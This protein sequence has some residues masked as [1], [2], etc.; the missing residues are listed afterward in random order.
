MGAERM[1]IEQ[2]KYFVEVA[3]CGSIRKASE[4]LF[5]AQQSLSQSVKK[6]ET[7]LGVSLLERSLGGV[8][9]TREGEAVLS[10]A[11]AVLAEQDVLTGQLAAIAREKQKQNLKGKLNIY[12]FGVYNLFILPSALKTF[13][14]QYPQVKIKIFTIDFELLMQALQNQSDVSDFLGLVILPDLQPLVLKDFVGEAPVQ[15]FPLVRG[16]YLLCCSQAHPLAKKRHVS[17][18]QLSGEPIVDYTMSQFENGA[19]YKIA[20][21]YGYTLPELRMETQSANLWLDMI[22]EGQGIGFMNE[23]L[24]DGMKRADFAGIDKV[25]VVPLTEPVYGILGCI[26]GEQRG[27][28]VEKFMEFL[29]L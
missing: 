10:F 24:Y 17:L 18:A 6:L 27:A 5:M 28:T 1:R 15:F 12:A 20:Q 2:L 19:F 8:T 13:R 7:E 9:L 23:Y 25:V 16:Q 11:E 22:A 21:N 26:A 4:H 3:R 29:A 14:Q